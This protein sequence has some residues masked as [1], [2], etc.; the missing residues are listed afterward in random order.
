M[1]ILRADHAATGA[2]YATM[3][4]ADVRAAVATPWLGVGSDF[5]ATAPDG[6][7]AQFVHPRAYGTF[8]RIL[9]RYAREQH[10]LSLAAAVHK[11]TGVP[12]ERL[13]LRERGLLR[14]GWAA[15]IAVF[16]AATIADE[17]T[18]QDSN[19]PSV[20]VRY[21]LVNGRFTLDDGRLTTER[22]GRAIRGPGWPG[23]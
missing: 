4:E 17:A 11:M 21:V 5:G 2:A 22:P 16:D 6:P 13:G 20:G 23:R 10:A 3:S 7:L 14:E 1:D 9:A 15:D 18:F 12:A 19:R 8:P